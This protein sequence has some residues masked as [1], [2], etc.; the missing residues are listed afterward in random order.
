MSSF[1]FLET[2]KDSKNAFRDSLGEFENLHELFFH[3]LLIDSTVTFHI[4]RNYLDC[5]VPLI[6]DSYTNDNAS[7]EIFDE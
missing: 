1:I 5:T 6:I 4:D 3:F 7:E 2:N